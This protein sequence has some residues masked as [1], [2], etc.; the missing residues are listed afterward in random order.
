MFLAL[1][2]TGGLVFGYLLHHSYHWY[3]RNYLYT[4][5]KRASLQKLCSLLKREK[6][7]EDILAL[8]SIACYETEDQ[9]T[10]GACRFQFSIIHSI[11]GTVLSILAG[12]ILSFLIVSLELFRYPVQMSM[13]FVIE[14]LFVLPISVLLYV[15]CKEYKYRFK[16]ALRI[17]DFIVMQ[18]LE[19]L[20]KERKPTWKDI[21]EIMQKKGT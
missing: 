7:D 3:F 5:S 4:Q 15:L 18:N 1:F 13:P 8:H 16:L 21:Q 9:K 12:Y 20:V 11:G 2:L 10:L 19:N 14:V 6:A 17:E